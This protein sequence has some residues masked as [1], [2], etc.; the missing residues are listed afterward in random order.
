MVT[1]TGLEL[2]TVK[3]LPTPQNFFSFKRYGWMSQPFLSHTPLN[4]SSPLSP[5]S[6][7]LHRYCSSLGVAQECMVKAVPRLLASHKSI[8][9]QHVPYLPVPATVAPLSPCIPVHRYC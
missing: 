2:S 9:V 6:V 3:S 4:R 8:S 7:P 1:V 5:Q